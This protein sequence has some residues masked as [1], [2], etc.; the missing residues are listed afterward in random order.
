MT[1]DDEVSS[2]G[3]LVNLFLALTLDVTEDDTAGLV[4]VLFLLLL[5]LRVA[6][7]MVQI[8]GIRRLVDL[9]SIEKLEV[10]G[11]LEMIRKFDTRINKK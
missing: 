9:V 6:G 8:L 4:E 10:L 3:F 7:A 1:V 2:S 5:R 11:K